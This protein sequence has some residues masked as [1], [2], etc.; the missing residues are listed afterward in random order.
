MKFS[1]VT[2]CRGSSWTMFTSIESSFVQ[3]FA[4]KRSLVA[5][6]QGGNPTIRPIMT[7]RWKSLCKPQL[8]TWVRFSILVTKYVWPSAPKFLSHMFWQAVLALVQTRIHAYTD[9]HWHCVSCILMACSQYLY[10]LYRTAIKAQ[11][12]VDLSRSDK[13]FSPRKQLILDSWW[14]VYFVS[15][16]RLLSPHSG[17]VWKYDIPK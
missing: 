3:N 1:C 8:L 12:L 10:I 9:M 4:A 13:C 11:E 5:V 17:F 2:S 6:L 7:S 14:F 16:T 15:R